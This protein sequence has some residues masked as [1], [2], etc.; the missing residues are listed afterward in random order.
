MRL[1]VINYGRRCATHPTVGIQLEESSAGGAPL[2]TI[3]AP[4]SAGA[5]DVMALVPSTGALDL[6]GAAL[7]VR[8]DLPAG[9]DVGRLGHYRAIPSRISDRS[10]RARSPAR[11]KSGSRPSSAFCL[12]CAS[13]GPVSASS[14]SP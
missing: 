12:R 10:F 9:A 14:A 6:T 8:H 7:T 1:D 13:S 11:S 5:F 3:A 4:G 2:T